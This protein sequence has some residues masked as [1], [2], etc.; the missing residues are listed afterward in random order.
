M[1]CDEC[2]TYA[3]SGKWINEVVQGLK[4]DKAKIKKHAIYDNHKKA[5]A[6][7]LAK[8]QTDKPGSVM[9]VAIKRITAANRAEA[10]S[11][12]KNVK[13]LLRCVYYLCHRKN[14]LFADS[15]NNTYEMMVQNGDI[16]L[17]IWLKK[18][19]Q[20]A[21]YTSNQVIEEYLIAI[22]QWL[23][24]PILASLKDSS[25][26]TL[27]ADESTEIAVIEEMSICA[28]WFSSEGKIVE[29]FLGLLDLKS[30]NAETVTNAL[31]GFMQKKGIYAK[32][33]RAQGYDGASTMAG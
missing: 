21:K 14:A 18:A 23:E 9:D 22:S 29:H 16:E 4:N 33:M 19:P 28:R 1:L 31:V 2:I 13:K 6:K 26:F 12:R 3:S 7:K 15:F 20:N 32:H 30:C 27:M 11:N 25:M 24:N 17:D 8:E 10:I 5:I